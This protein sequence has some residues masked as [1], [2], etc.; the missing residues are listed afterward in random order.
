LHGR[1]LVVTR[2][3]WGVLVVFTLITYSA[4]FLVYVAHAQDECTGTPWLTSCR[5]GQLL[6]ASAQ[7][8]HLSVES[9]GVF[10]IVLVIIW[11]SVWFAVAAMIVWHK[12]D[13]WMALLIALGLT[14]GAGSVINTAVLGQFDSTWLFLSQIVNFLGNVT[15]FLVF[16]LFPDGRFTPRWMRRWAGA[17]IALSLGQSFFPDSALN[18]NNW[19]FPFNDLVVF[20]VFGC[21]VFAQVY[22]YRRISSSVQRQQT[23]WIVFAVATFILGALAESLGLE[24]LPHYFPLLR[25]PDALYQVLDALVWNFSIVLLPL[26]FGIAILRYRLYDIDVLINRTLVYGILTATLALVYVGTILVLQSVLR[27]LTGRIGENQLVVVGSTLVIAVL[28][29]PLRKRIQTTIDRR[30]Y[31]RKYDAART[32]ATFSETLREEVDLDQLS[33]QLVGV[34]Q[35]TMQPTHAWLWLRKSE[36]ELTRNTEALGPHP[37]R[38]PQKGGRTVGQPIPPYPILSQGGMIGS[39]STQRRMSRR[40]VLAGLATVGVAVTAGGFA[41]W[42]FRYPR[43][44]TYGG[45]ADWVYTVAW[46]PDGTRLASGSRDKT[47]QI[48]DALD[49]GQVFTYRRHA[50]AI[51][52]VA[53]SPDG[54][55]LASASG[56]KTVQVWDAADGKHMFTYRG[57]GDQVITVAWSPNGRRL[58]SGSY[59]KT[60]QVWDAADGRQILSYRGHTADVEGVAWSPDGRRLASASVDKTVQVWDAAD[61]GRVLTYRGHAAT[62]YTASWS[63]NGRRL[64]SASADKTVQVW[65]AVDG[66]HSFTYRGHADEAITASWSL[67]GRRLASASVDKTV[68]VWDATDGRHSFTYRGHGDAVITVAWSPDGKHLASSSVDNTVQVWS[69]V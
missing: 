40:S 35:E 47:V 49:G 7:L 19:P 59:D 45:H 11:M 39:A 18:F 42:L 66:R 2:V 48:W 13:D 46:S 62:A 32:I 37:L 1:W 67:D 51:Y 33:E 17:W 58:A 15:L 65:D 60:V 21:L 29:E 61:G 24:L 28:F 23:K 14:M 43:L 41:G 44:Y 31:R 9:Y 10:N 63:P 53:W 12:S 34:V 4:G 52:T 20:G 16:S 25:L 64:A 38:S 69:E 6:T 68:Q 50:A 54:R 8:F 22:R 55:H 27:G 36:S 56:D 30:F 26:S 5:L 3:V 57:H